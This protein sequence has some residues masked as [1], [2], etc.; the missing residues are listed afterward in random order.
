[1]RL[2]LLIALAITSMLAMACT[3]DNTEPDP[4][5]TAKAGPPSDFIGPRLVYL[6]PDG[7]FRYKPTRDTAERIGDGCPR[8]ARISVA[9]N[10][11]YFATQ[12]S[13]SESEETLAL[14]ISDGRPAG[15]LDLPAAGGSTLAFAAQPF[16]YA[17]VTH[18]PEPGAATIRVVDRPPET[19]L[20][21]PP[22]LL[23]GVDGYTAW[24]PDGT[25]LAYYRLAGV[26]CSPSCEPGLT[27]W[28]IEDGQEVATNIDARPLQFIDDRRLLVANAFDTAATFPTYTAMLLDLDSGA[29]TPVPRLD[30]GAQ[31][32]LSPD[33]A[34]AAVI[35]PVPGSQQGV[36]ILDLA[37]LE[38][39][40][41]PGS[42]I[43]FPSDHIPPPNV[44][45]AGNDIYWV[46][47]PFPN[48]VLY[49]A[50]LNGTQLEQLLDVEAFVL[51]ISP[52]K[53]LV[54][55]KGAGSNSITIANIDG[56]EPRAV[57]DS[58]SPPDAPTA[59]DWVVAAD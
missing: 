8:F 31:F 50:K 56:S 41:V 5:A 17:L 59:F 35:G 19:D 48:S 55:Y 25:M 47:Q 49:R 7:L 20:V 45:F 44:F 6:T 1:M 37:S 10:G 36:S 34:K 21:L 39:T 16:V 30:N 11:D 52:D 46:D 12:C 38:E 29:M 27:L 22:V 57:P 33:R 13:P 42:R 4:L 18:P 43:S 23:E 3:D 14:W 58:G 24:S 54:A 26:R 51:R 9:P 32:W 40:P 2:L 15:T 53:S 28:D